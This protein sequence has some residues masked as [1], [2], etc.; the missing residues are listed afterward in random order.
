[1]KRV[2][3]VALVASLVL[4]LSFTTVSSARRAP[5][6]PFVGA[7]YSGDQTMVIAPMR[8]YAEKYIIVYTDQNSGICC[9]TDCVTLCG[10]LGRGTGDAAGESALAV[11][12]DLWCQGPPPFYSGPLDFTMIY[13]AATDTFDGLGVTWL[14]MGAKAP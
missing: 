2:F 3:V 1:M 11:S 4:T 8:K 12:L 7:W 10:A 5:P 6:D 9:V 13:N 14:R